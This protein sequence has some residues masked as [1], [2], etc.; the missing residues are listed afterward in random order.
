MP[1][2]WWTPSA[3]AETATAHQIPGLGHHQAEIG[4]G[5]AAEVAVRQVGEVGAALPAPVRAGR[6]R[7]QI[8]LEHQLD[9]AVLLPA[10]RPSAGDRR[11]R[12][13]ERARG[14]GQFAKPC[15]RR[16]ASTPGC[17]AP[18]ELE[19]V[20]VGRALVGVAL[21]PDGVARAGLDAGQEGQQSVLLE[22][23]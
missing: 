7:D 11:D 9:P 10:L 20:E 23:R 5:R 2:A 6:Q 16:K 12:L 3:G 1:S 8:A 14:H 22:R 15:S 21:E 19:V 17:A 4:L 18:R 13:A